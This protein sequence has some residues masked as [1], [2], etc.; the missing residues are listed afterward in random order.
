MDFE[1]SMTRLNE[2]PERMSAQALPLEES[3]RLYAEAAE[4]VKGCKEYIEQAKLRVEQ[5]EA[6]EK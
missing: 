4:L 3:V 6:G 5:L 1:Q 2:I